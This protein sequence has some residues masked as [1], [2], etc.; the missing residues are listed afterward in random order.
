MR[1]MKLGILL[2]LSLNTMAVSGEKTCHRIE[3]QLF[4]VEMQTYRQGLQGL[5]THKC[6]ELLPKVAEAFKDGSATSRFDAAEV[7]ALSGRK[8]YGPLLIQAYIDAAR[9][10]PG[11]DFGPSTLRNDILLA[12]SDIPHGIKPGETDSD[13]WKAGPQNLRTECVDRLRELHERYSA[14]LDVEV[15]KNVALAFLDLLWDTSAASMIEMI[16]DFYSANDEDIREG[17]MTALEHVP[18]EAALPLLSQGARDRSDFVRFQAVRILVKHD[19]DAVEQLLR[20]RFGIETDPPTLR[21]IRVRLG[22][23]TE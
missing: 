12:C 13:V 19:G 10:A 23:P 20:E 18:L 6:D 22:M 2:S 15:A 9:R 16:N 4:S 8:E 5:L 7:L 11:Y 1:C 3:R 17:A 21:M 14:G